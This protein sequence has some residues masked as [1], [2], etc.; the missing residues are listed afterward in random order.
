M[1]W[2]VSKVEGKFSMENQIVS[3]LAENG[4]LWVGTK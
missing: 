3:K 1:Y 2:L 4:I